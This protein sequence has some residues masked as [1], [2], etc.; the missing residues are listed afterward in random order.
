MSGRNGVDALGVAA[1]ALSLIISFFM[2]AFGVGMFG[3][4]RIFVYGPMI[5]AFF[6]MF[7]RNTQKRAEE[8]RK[9]MSVINRFR[10]KSGYNAYNTDF[11]KPKRDTKNYK[12]LKCPSCRAQLRIPRGKGKLNITCPKCHA[13]FKGKS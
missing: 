10:R 11:Q 3:W 6:R 7:S 8:N 13:Q 4:Q 2:T 12:Y 5:Y 9:F 1:L